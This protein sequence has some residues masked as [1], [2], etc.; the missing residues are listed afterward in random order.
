MGAGTNCLV[1]GVARGV[2]MFDCV[3]QLVLPKWYGHDLN[4][5]LN[6]RIL[7]LLMIGVL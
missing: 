5:R 4:G 6:I 3:F 7:N 2:D 1:E